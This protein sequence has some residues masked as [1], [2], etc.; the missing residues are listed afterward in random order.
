MLSSISPVGEA[1]RQ[2]RWSVTVAAY[3]VGS[4]SAGAMTGA[5]LGLLGSTGWTL[6]GRLPSTTAQLVGI[7]SLA[8][9]GLVLDATSGVPS[10]HRQVDDRWL[11]TY[12]G[13]VY[14]IG[15][16][17][18][19][20]TGVATIV[21]ASIV[22]V[23]WATAALSGS[24]RT[25]GL[26]GLVFGVARALPLVAAGRIRTVA[27]LRRTLARIDAARERASLVTRLGQMGVALAAL[28][29][30]VR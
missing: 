30:V 6:A 25:G 14:G 28:V 17:A 7:G 13:W 26:I 11:T 3:V 1:S 21:P 22:W 19:L 4:A 20:G 16:G 18:Q 27:A 23:M 8:A 5:L 24:V 15:F 10:I 2:Q 29:V 12:R 9:I